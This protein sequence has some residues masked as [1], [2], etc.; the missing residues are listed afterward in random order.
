MLNNLEIFP[1]VKKIRLFENI[2][3]EIQKMLLEVS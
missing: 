1:N 2:W 3:K